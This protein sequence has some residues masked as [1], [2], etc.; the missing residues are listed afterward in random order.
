[1]NVL[2]L[3][4]SNKKTKGKILLMV[5]ASILNCTANG[6]GL[7][8][9][10]NAPLEVSARHYT[11]ENLTNAKHTYDLKP[12][13]E[14]YFNVDHAQCGVGNDSCGKNPP[15]KQY[16]VKVEPVAFGFTVTPVK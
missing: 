2:K 6:A 11:D 15:L 5:C 8:V 4:Q 16:H 13:P 7:E 12:K 14:I 9:K 3:L 10:G 1:M